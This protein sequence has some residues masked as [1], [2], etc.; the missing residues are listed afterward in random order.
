LTERQRNS[1][2]A[3]YFLSNISYN[4]LGGEQIMPLVIAGA[5]IGLAVY[6][7]VEYFKK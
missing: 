6:L 1:V 5:C 2:G 3:L 4:E 7:V